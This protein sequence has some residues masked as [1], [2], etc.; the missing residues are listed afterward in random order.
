MILYHW[1]YSVVNRW[2]VYMIV[3]KT[4]EAESNTSANTKSNEIRCILMYCRRLTVISTRFVGIDHLA[5]KAWVWF[6]VGCLRRPCRFA[7]VRIPN[8]ARRKSTG[9]YGGTVF[10]PFIQNATT[11]I[12]TEQPFIINPQLIN[13]T[14][15]WTIHERSTSCCS[16]KL[17]ISPRSLAV[18][19]S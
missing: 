6:F 2:Y 11:R 17:L 19:S 12:Q 7:D 5:R 9:F 10:L 18:S 15:N 3:L 1:K 14:C 16:H 13:L 4:V 8:N